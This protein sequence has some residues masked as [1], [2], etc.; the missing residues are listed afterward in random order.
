MFS[1]VAQRVKQIMALP[2]DQDK[3][4]KLKSVPW[5]TSNLL[6]FWLPFGASII[7]I[8]IG[9]ILWQLLGWSLV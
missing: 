8:F 1:G 4:G 3:F 9:I 7:E 2:N 5:Q 6:G